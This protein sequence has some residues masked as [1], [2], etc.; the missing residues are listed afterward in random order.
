MVNVVDASAIATISAGIVGSDG[1]EKTGD[2]RLILTADN[3]YAGGTTISAGTLQ[4]GAGGASGSVSGDIANDGALIFNRS[5]AVL[6]PA[7]SPAPARWR[8]RARAR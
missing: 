2:G 3:T 6:I 1:L 7:A 5:N 4:L 8:S